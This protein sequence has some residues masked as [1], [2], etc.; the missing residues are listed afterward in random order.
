M[1][2]RYNSKKD[3]LDELDLYEELILKKINQLDYDSALKKVRSAIILIE[4]AQ[5]SFNLDEKLDIFLRL[6]QRIIDERSSHRQRYLRKYDNLLKEELS[7]ENLDSFLKLLA[8]LKNEVDG[9]AIKFNLGDIQT[10]IN[11]YFKYLKRIYGIISSY[12]ILEF[13][14]ASDQIL[15]FAK[16]IRPEKYNNLKTLTLSLYRN[17]ITNKLREISKIQN[18]C[19]MDELCEK[20]AISR[21]DLLKIFEIIGETPNNPIKR[22]SLKTQ[23]IVFK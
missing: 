19:Y 7:E 23:E 11:S 9:V 12:R 1:E 18:R 20:L 21:N 5:E 22:Y 4:E 3:L 14:K 15:N 2:I 17:L 16:D 6:N 8:M 13:N 10:H